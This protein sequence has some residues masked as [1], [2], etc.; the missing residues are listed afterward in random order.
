MIK[1]LFIYF[2]CKDVNDYLRGREKTL[3][4]FLIKNKKFWKVWMCWN[5]IGAMAPKTS[6]HVN[7]WRVIII[8]AD[9]F[10]ESS[11]KLEINLKKTNNYQCIFTFVVDKIF[12]SHD[13]I[14]LA[15]CTTLILSW[16][17]DKSLLKPKRAHIYTKR[18]QSPWFKTHDNII[19]SKPMV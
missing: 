10:L 14:S 9:Y 6:P 13:F 7:H 5:S 1:N 19:S 17:L 4:K 2:K 12:M 8:D 18:H 15:T 3:K 11:A 16:I